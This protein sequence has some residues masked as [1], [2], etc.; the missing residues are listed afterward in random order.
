MNAHA[1][2][3]T[4]LVAILALLGF[5]PAPLAAELTGGPFELTAQTTVGGGSSSGESLALSGVAYAQASGVYSGGPFEL[6]SPPADAFLVTIW[7]VNLRIRV[8]GLG[9]A[10]ISWPAGATGYR[11]QWATRLGPGA[12]WQ[13]A[14]PVPQATEFAFPLADNARFFRLVK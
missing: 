6:V 1:P 8:S 3:R 2:S 9:Q 11:L 13:D 10:S 12:D 4:V 14:A 5:S 7:N